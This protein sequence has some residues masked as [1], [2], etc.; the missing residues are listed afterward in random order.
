L[1]HSLQ[2]FDVVIRMMLLVRIQLCVCKNK[3]I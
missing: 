1:R 2:Q 3:N